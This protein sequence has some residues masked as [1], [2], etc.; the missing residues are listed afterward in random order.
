M[1]RRL[2]A[3]TVAVV[4]LGAFLGACSESTKPKSLTLAAREFRFTGAPTGTIQGGL[5][6]FKLRNSGRQF[7]V[8]E[9]VRVDAGK[10]DADVR[11]AIGSQGEPPS[12]VH[13]DTFEVLR[14]HG[15][16]LCLHDL[17]PDQPWIRT[18]E[19]TYVRFHGPAA[20]ERKYQGR[21][22]P[23]RLEPVAARLEGWLADGVDVYA[24][25]NNDYE[26]HAV[27]DAAWLA[28]RLAG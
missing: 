25:F 19:W 22:G 24:Y 21:Y 10:T 6:T 15:A 17:L 16:A 5:T 14:R 2:L 20:L 27:T 23:K 28:G 1:S 13:D 4:V 11:K 18:A 9:L 3:G 26:G 12:W 7:H 8:M